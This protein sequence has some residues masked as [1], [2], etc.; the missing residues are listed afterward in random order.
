M[1]EPAIIG[2]A[3]LVGLLVFFWKRFG[4]GSGHALGNRVAAH[5]GIPRSHF[6]TLLDHGVKGSSRDLLHALEK[7][8]LDPEQAS[9]E[10][11]PT[12]ARGIER[13]EER[14]GPQEIYERVKPTVVRLVAAFERKHGAAES[15]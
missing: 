9:V 13:L 15:E 4:S 5:L 6:Y 3:T 8:N 14:F 12:L 11:G 1:I 10:L 7:A 2:V